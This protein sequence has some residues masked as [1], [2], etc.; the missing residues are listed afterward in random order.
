MATKLC[1]PAEVDLA[2]SRRSLLLVWQNPDSR[3]FIK[4]GQL[5][6]LADGRC[7]RLPFHPEV[8][9][10]IRL[11]RVDAAVERQQLF[12]VALQRQR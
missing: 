8:G 11:A 4:V 2:S 12:A 6:V 7:V 3:R 1:S 10:K 9:G 5:D